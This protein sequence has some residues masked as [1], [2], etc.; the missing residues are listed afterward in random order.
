MI[1][2]LIIYPLDL[3][4]TL[5]PQHCALTILQAPEQQKVAKHFPISEISLVLVLRDK[6]R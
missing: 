2:S 1:V 5:F 3:S 4:Y 6:N